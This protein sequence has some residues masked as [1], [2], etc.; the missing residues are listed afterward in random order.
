MN[1]NSLSSP[2]ALVLPMDLE[3]L[4]IG[5][6]DTTT[7]ML[8]P[9]YDFMLLPGIHQ[10][11]G[12]RRPN[13]TEN[14]L[15]GGRPFA[16]GRPALSGVHLHWSLP[17][18]LRH[19]GEDSSENDK[20]SGRKP[21]GGFPQVPNRWLVTRLVFQPDGTSA[22][23][24]WVV[25]S[26]RLESTPSAGMGFRHPSVP[27]NLG[28]PDQYNRYIGRSYPA[29]NW[30]EFNNAQ[31]FVPLTAL[32]YGDP[33]FASFYPNCSTVFG[34]H[35]DL[36]DV[37]ADKS[38]LA[39]HV[40]GWYGGDVDDCL[41]TEAGRRSIARFNSWNEADGVPERMLCN[42]ALHEIE[43]NSKGRYINPHAVESLSC[44]IGASPAEALSALAAAAADTPGLEDGLNALQFG[45]IEN[46]ENRP[47]AA[48]VFASR[49]HEAGFTSSSGGSLWIIRKP[50][51]AK[52]SMPE[53]ALPDW[54]ARRLER[55]CTRQQALDR[56]R[57]KLTAARRQLYSDWYKYQ[58]ASY[59]SQNNVPAKPI[60]ALL[61]EQ[62][63]NILAEDARIKRRMER[64][65]KIATRATALLP[66]GYVLETEAAPRFWRA[67][68]P[69]LMLLSN[70]TKIH[71][72]STPFK[73]KNGSRLPCRLSSQIVSGVTISLDDK[74]LQL[75]NDQWLSVPPCP[76]LPP[77]LAGAINALAAEAVLFSGSARPSI[78]MRLVSEQE[79]TLATAEKVAQKITEA[80]G[81]FLA[82][83]AHSE[84]SFNSHYPPQPSLQMRDNFVPW[85]PSQ[86][87]Y[88]VRLSQPYAS[89]LVQHTLMNHFEWAEGS[90]LHIKG[91]DTNF[92][93]SGLYS[94]TAMLAQHGTIQLVNAAQA[95]LERHPDAPEL[96]AL[97]DWITALPLAT[98]TMSDFGAALLML[99]PSGQ[100]PVFD[101]YADTARSKEIEQIAKAV[102]SENWFAPRSTNPMNPLRAGELKLQRLRLIDR[103][104]RFED[105]AEPTEQQPNIRPPQVLIARGL[106]SQTA[107]SDIAT[108]SLPAR[109]TQPA[110]LQFRW[111]SAT[112]SSVQSNA[113]PSTSPVMGWVLIDNVDGGISFFTYDGKALGTMLCSAGLN[114]QVLWQSP[115]PNVTFDK[116]NEV[117]KPAHPELRAFALAL[118][119]S[120]VEGV[121]QFHAQTREA[122]QNIQLGSATADDALSLLIGR[123]LALVSATLALELKGSAA[124]DCSWEALQRRVND[125]HSGQDGGLG[126]V[127]F[128]V[129][130]GSSGRMNDGLL[131]YWAV[132]KGAT[133][134][135]ETYSPLKPGTIKVR[136][137]E[138][139]PVAI[140]MLIDPR[141]SV[142]A[143]T[144]ILPVKSITLPTSHYN[145][146]LSRLKLALRVGPVL[147][148]EGSQPSLPQ[149]MTKSKWL[150][151]SGNSTEHQ[152]TDNQ[153]FDATHQLARQEIV[154]GWAML[155]EPKDI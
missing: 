25:E 43:W 51:N 124:L 50:E 23:R 71:S 37:P 7:A 98:Q 13:L 48:D 35:D 84:V 145:A 53:P 146:A 61:K 21:G 30:H 136:P 36:A 42:S 132:Q 125:D 151:H 72:L 120:G 113:H 143:T 89:P 131:A 92:Y 150:W 155:Q 41:S 69:S 15:D 83:Q 14:L 63:T 58:L 81:V 24:R 75:V 26:D 138:E 139:Q 5:R 108:A 22:I 18:A 119:D 59:A 11:Q 133:N 40:V 45:Q 73:Y 154:E 76:G 86:F 129:R 62:A 34:F 20:A 56:R 54:A 152:L 112:S 29:D 144:G 17:E 153:G 104:G 109:I 31:R 91:G 9:T 117:L 95:V 55:L 99:K 6:V 10:P 38:R 87:Q 115:P 141:G 66:P 57:G 90:D 46:A 2:Q 140:T 3:A 134:F 110:R 32:G 126:K 85:L 111:V 107:I 4:C 94:G 1:Q 142:Q 137:D 123:P 60:F 33:S 12:V 80:T 68:D 52:E 8:G 27:F 105:Y 135:N 44:S 96:A 49:L 70:E 101:P 149:P 148:A 47:D 100:L 147:T 103:F 130:L 28:K 82:G 88:E 39:Y 116:P 114:A 97:R 118:Y 93:S 19:G 67:R 102:G 77:I 78:I 65:H 16:D 64:L 74:Q 106:R 79:A 122:L 121:R 127:E 128:P